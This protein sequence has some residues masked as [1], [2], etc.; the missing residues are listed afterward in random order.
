[1][2]HIKWSTIHSQA[3]QVAQSV[4]HIGWEGDEVVSVE[5]PVHI[6]RFN[7]K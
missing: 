7:D 3:L 6:A 5:I 1:M 4:E 2:R